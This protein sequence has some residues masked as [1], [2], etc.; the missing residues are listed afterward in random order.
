M[1]SRPGRATPTVGR[2][3]RPSLS[4][5]AYRRLTALALVLLVAIVVTGAGVRL[6]G[7]GLG[8][9]DW[10]AC[11]QDRF[12]PAWSFSP[13]VEFGNR[14]VTGVVSAAVAAAVLGALVR[15]PRRRDLVWLALGLVAGVIGQIVLGGLLVKADLDPRFTSG[16]FLLSMLLVADAVWLHHRAGLPEPLPPRRGAVGPRS[17]GATRLA[18]AVAALAGVVLATGAVV[19][20]SGPHGGDDHAARFPLPLEDVT[21]IHSGAV[22]LLIAAVLVA[23]LSFARRGPAIAAR[24]ARWLF[25]L[26]VGQ[27]TVGYVQYFTG[28]PPALVAV[29]VLGATVGWALALQLLLDVVDAPRGVPVTAREPGPAAV[30]VL[31]GG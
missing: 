23:V 13:W 21:R 29:H 10:P 18:A 12:V 8:C 26:L 9:S 1:P 16:H 27:G 2:V 15:A 25:V 7:S 5:V 20:G 11:E 4:P 31:S 6:T 14:L 17:P 22:W 24:R 3:R 30:P 28:V 19:T